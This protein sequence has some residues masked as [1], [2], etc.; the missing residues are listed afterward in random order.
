MYFVISDQCKLV[1]SITSDSFKRLHTSAA[2]P[3][4]EEIVWSILDNSRMPALETATLSLHSE[5]DLDL[6]KAYLRS[7]LDLFDT[8]YRSLKSAALSIGAETDNDPEIT[9]DAHLE[10]SRFLSMAEALKFLIVL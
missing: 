2:G 5:D 9:L 6:P 7:L 10:V 3:K 8:E 4:T 1:W